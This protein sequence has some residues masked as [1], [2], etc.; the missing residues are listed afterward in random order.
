MYIACTKNHGTDYLQVHEAYSIKENGVA[1]NRS[2][3]VKNIGP[4]SRFDDGKSDYLKR[5][6]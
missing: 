6:R 2:R 4:L 1:K 3:L 5:L